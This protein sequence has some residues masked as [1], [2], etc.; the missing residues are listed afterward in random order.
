MNSKPLVR[1]LKDS[2]IEEITEYSASDRRFGVN[3]SMM[4]H[5]AEKEESLIAGNIICLSPTTEEI[6]LQNSKSVVKNWSRVVFAVGL[7]TLPFYFSKFGLVWGCFAIILAVLVNHDS[8]LSYID[9]AELTEK[10][11][12]PSLVLFLFGKV[13]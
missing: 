10:Q 4:P 7:F 8:Y 6:D 9:V 13:V 12:Y 3:T 11:D 5:F 2:I 1:S